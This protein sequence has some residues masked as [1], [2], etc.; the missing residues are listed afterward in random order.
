MVSDH[1]ETSLLLNIES[2]VNIFGAFR[3]T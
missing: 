2:L 3:L 1:D